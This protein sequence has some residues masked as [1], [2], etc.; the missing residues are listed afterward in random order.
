MIDGKDAGDSERFLV[1]IMVIGSVFAGAE[2]NPQRD[3]PDSF[4][5]ASGVLFIRIYDE[6][7]EED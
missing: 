4:G 1:E 3:I 6:L 2:I 7:R 5:E